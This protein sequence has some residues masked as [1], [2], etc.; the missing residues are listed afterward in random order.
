MNICIIDIIS[1]V[2]EVLF[3]VLLSKDLTV[4]SSLKYSET[5][6]AYVI[7]RDSGKPRFGYECYCMKATRLSFKYALRQ[8]KS[9]EDSMRTNALE[10]SLLARNIDSFCK[11]AKLLCLP[12]KVNGC[13][14]ESEIKH[15][16]TTL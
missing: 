1:T 6:N 8:F 5:R 3:I 7:W 16:V 11:H 15:V 12:T 4:F 13:V 14:G 9:L 10:N 2:F